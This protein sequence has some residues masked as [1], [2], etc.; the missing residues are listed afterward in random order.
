MIRHLTRQLGLAVLGLSIL[1]SYATWDQQMDKLQ[2]RIDAAAHVAS[3]QKSPKI[4]VSK[5]MKL[6]PED[7]RKC[8]DL[9]PKTQAIAIKYLAVAKK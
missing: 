9:A 2:Q 6:S 3:P 1:C 7:C 4:T 8:V 5:F